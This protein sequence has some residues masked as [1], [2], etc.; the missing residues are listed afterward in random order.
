MLALGNALEMN[1]IKHYR[2]P[3]LR[4]GHRNYNHYDLVPWNNLLHVDLL[5]SKN[6]IAFIWYFSRL[7]VISC[8]IMGIIEVLLIA[9]G[10]SMDAFAVAIAKGLSARRV[11]FRHALTA[12]VWFGGFQALMPT[13]G[14]FGGVLFSSFIGEWDHWIAWVLLTLIG[15]N[16]I[17]ESLSRDEEQVDAGFSAWK[18]L[19]LAI[20][21]S[22]DALAVGVSFAFLEMEI[23]MP[24]VV[25]G[26]TT[27]LFSMLGVYVGK[28]FGARFKSKAE[29]L[30]GIV[31]VAIG[32]KI[33]FEHVM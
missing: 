10:V 21:T 4:V 9:V 1:N 12:G 28:M 22:I 15:V 20:A 13:I 5:G 7:F 33:L 29:L 11:G 8:R 3:Y 6:K 23:L 18:M 25:I 27:M 19:P 2:W 32:C 31:L 30:G 24:V 16:M 26:I 14:Y 17:K